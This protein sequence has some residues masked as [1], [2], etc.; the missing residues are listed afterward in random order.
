MRERGPEERKRLTRGDMV[1][2]SPNYGVLSRLGELEG[3]HIAAALVPATIIA[4]LFFFDHNVSSQLAQEGLNLKKP[5]V[6]PCRHRGR[7]V[8]VRGRV[9][10]AHAWS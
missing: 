10:R 4:V 2:G 1:D 9:D 7:R 3:W 5:T 8:G 6:R